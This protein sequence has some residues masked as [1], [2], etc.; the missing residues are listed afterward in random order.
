MLPVSAVLANNEVMM[1][2][3]PGQHG[4]TYGGNP[5]ACVVAEASL[6]VLIDEGLAENATKQGNK[7]MKA[8]VEISKLTNSSASGKQL[9]K[10]VRG[11]GLLMAVVIEDEGHDD[12]AWDICLKLADLG[13]VQTNT[14][15]TINTIYNE[16]Q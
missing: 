16:S 9:I 14:L 4:S 5:L 8:L 3:K 7:L 1:T 13:L 15:H 2:I 11:R 6:Q 12:L 10:Q